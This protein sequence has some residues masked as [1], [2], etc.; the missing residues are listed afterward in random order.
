MGARSKNVESKIRTGVVRPMLHR[1][2]A[3]IHDLDVL[4]M[5]TPRPFLSHTHTTPFVDKTKNDTHPFIYSYSP[6]W[7]VQASLFILFQFQ[8]IKY[9]FSLR[10][11]MFFF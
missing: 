10:K 2:W 6:F 4:Y 7:I 9:E 3:V 1:V 11:F 8:M 5:K